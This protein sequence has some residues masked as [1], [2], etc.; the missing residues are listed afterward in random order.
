MPNMLKLTPIH[1]RV[2]DFVVKQKIDHDGV[3]PSVLEIKKA[4]GINSASA[5]RHYLDSLVLFGMIEW[6]GGE[7]MI[8]IPGAR[9]MPPLN[10]VLYS[11]FKRAERVP[12]VP[13]RPE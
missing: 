7:R 13:Y 4:C 12:S 1:F 5:V 8:S 3:A 10:D 2:Y 9:W 6:Q 11:P